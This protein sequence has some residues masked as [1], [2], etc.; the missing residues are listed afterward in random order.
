MI[1]RDCNPR[2][3]EAV[4]SRISTLVAMADSL[5]RR[6]WPRGTVACAP[7]RLVRESAASTRTWLSALD[8]RG[9]G[10][11]KPKCRQGCQHCH[12]NHGIAGVGQGASPLGRKTAWCWLER[13][14]PGKFKHLSAAAPPSRI[15]EAG[16]HFTMRRGLYS[17]ATSL[18]VPILLADHVAGA[19]QAPAGAALAG[20]ASITSHSTWMVSP[21]NTGPLMSNCMP[22]KA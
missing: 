3:V 9:A 19:H 8:G 15:Q 2:I 12:H 16:R 21:A 1:R 17:M 6:S 5:L 11:K 7:L 18:A 4:R 20:R 14:R 10:E 13:R 22:R